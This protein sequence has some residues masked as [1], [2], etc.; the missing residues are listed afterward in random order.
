MR[1]RTAVF[2]ALS[3]VMMISSR[4]VRPRLL[5]WVHH[6]TETARESWTLVLV[7]TSARAGG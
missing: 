3:L 5:A 4:R 7:A 1:W 6:L 2:L